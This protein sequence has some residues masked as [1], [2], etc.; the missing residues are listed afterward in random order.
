MGLL[1]RVMWPKVGDRIEVQQQGQVVAKGLVTYVSD[2][3]I[4]I[5]TAEMATIN[6]DAGELSAGLEAHTTKIKKT[7]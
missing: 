5:Q 1:S 6:L 3:I 2:S 7:R 4:S